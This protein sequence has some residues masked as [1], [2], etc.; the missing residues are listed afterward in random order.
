MKEKKNTM[1]SYRYTKNLLLN[2]LAL[3]HNFSQKKIF[4][5]I[6]SSHQ[7]FIKCIIKLNCGYCIQDRVLSSERKGAERTFISF[8]A[9]W[10]AV[11]K[12]LA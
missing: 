8:L 7:K 2:V 1:I 11:D 3:Q 9:I 4:Q 5:I 6:A 10:L 12:I